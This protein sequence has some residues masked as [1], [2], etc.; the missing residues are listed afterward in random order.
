MNNTSDIY[1]EITSPQKQVL[2]RMVGKVV[3]PGEKG[4]FS[5]L[6]GHAPLISSLLEGDIVYSEG[7]KEESLHIKSGFVEV[8]D[9]RVS[10]CVEI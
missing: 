3:L 1:L 10:V 4:Q 9:N 2:G 7:D 6:P 8:R 5:V